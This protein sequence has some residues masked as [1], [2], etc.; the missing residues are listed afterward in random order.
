MSATSTQGGIFINYRR[1]DS[2]SVA[3]RLHDRLGRRFRKARIFMDVGSIQ[4]GSDFAKAIN[5]AVK[6]CEVLLAVIGPRWL[7]LK[8]PHGKRR[9]DDVDD[10]VRLELVAA[11][12]RDVRV[13]PLLVD[14]TPMP[15][16]SDLPESIN[17]LT[18]RN[19]LPLRHEAFAADA[20]QLEEILDQII[21]GNEK[22]LK[23]HRGN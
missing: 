1:E 15:K 6:D 14:G 10:Y 23:W 20:C 18:R 11:L 4:P 13:I 19:A 3:G 12:S 17:A 7:T 9:I 21:T 8:D 5:Q 2:G 22:L 16:G